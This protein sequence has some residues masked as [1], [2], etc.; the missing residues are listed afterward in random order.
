MY[1]NV[2]HQVAPLGEG[3][4]EEDVEVPNKA[5]D[6][7]EREEDGQERSGEKEEDNAEASAATAMQGQQVFP[8]KLK[9]KWNDDGTDAAEE[10]DIS[11]QVNK[12]VINYVHTS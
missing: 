12:H 6:G 4:G 7:Q 11:T 8:I 2:Y 5:G 10:M 1:R 9:R 3:A